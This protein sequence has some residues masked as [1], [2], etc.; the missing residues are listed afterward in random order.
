[1][2]RQ[3]VT[4]MMK[5]PEF[6]RPVPDNPG[7]SYVDYYYWCGK[8]DKCV[9]GTDEV[10]PLTPEDEARLKKERAY[11]EAYPPPICK[12]CQTAKNKAKKKKEAECE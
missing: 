5:Y 4:H 12:K 6:V 1:M 7:W 9:R 2:A 10:D 3:R 8:V 11:L